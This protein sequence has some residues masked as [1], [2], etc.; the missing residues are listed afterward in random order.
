MLC[1]SSFRGLVG[2]P[3]VF[4]PRP[5]LLKRGSG[6]RTLGPT[7][8]SSGLPRALGTSI[9]PLRHRLLSS[10]TFARLLGFQV[11]LGPS[12]GRPLGPAHCVSPAPRTAPGPPYMASGFLF[13]V[14]CFLM[15]PPGYLRKLK[16]CPS[17]CL[18][19][20][21]CGRTACL[22][23]RPAAPCPGITFHDTLRLSC[24]S[25]L[26]SASRDILNP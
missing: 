1:S 3:Y 8:S 10:V 16:H 5:S 25:Q 13:F 26:L 24:L 18:A 7:F 19:E 11:R 15:N 21:D 2:H 23:A 9:V 6:R 20:V 22:P 14:F 12:C 4:F 17:Q